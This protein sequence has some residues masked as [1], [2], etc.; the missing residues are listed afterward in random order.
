MGLTLEQ[1]K[2]KASALAKVIDNRAAEI[3]KA[4][5]YYQGEQ[6]LAFASEEYR[7]YFKER[8]DKF[9]DNW[10][11][12]V[13]DSPTER[14]EII[15]V[16]PGGDDPQADKDLM[17]VW[18][19]RGAD[20]ESGLAFLDAIIAKRSYG[21]VWGNDADETTPFVSFESATEAVVG[22]RPG[23][24]T[25]RVA[26]LKMWTEDDGTQ[27]ADLYTPDEVWALQRNKV[28]GGRTSSG[29]VIIS[30][31]VGEW[32]R[33]QTDEL[34]PK[35]NPLG[36]VPL[37]EFPNRPLLARQPLSDVAGVM[38]MQDA[39]NLLW[40]QLFVAADYASFPQRVILGAE[41]P[42]LPILD[43]NGQKVGDQPVDLRKFAVDRVVWLEN[44]NAK[45]AE[46][47]A[48]DLGV[49][50]GVIETGVGHMAAQTRTPQ[51]Y[52]IG[53]MANLSGDALVVAETGL[54]KRTEEKQLYMGQGGREVFALI[55]TAQGDQ[56]KAAAVRAG[57]VRWKDAAMRSEAQLVDAL[58]K[59]SALGMPFQWIAE[60]YGLSRTELDRVMAMRDEALTRAGMP[61]KPSPNDDN[62]E[63][64][65]ER[66]DDPVLVS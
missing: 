5:D 57:R 35:P 62:A 20:A 17:R 25:E 52:L 31:D 10:T 46:W 4:R 1:A 44:P 24:R 7:K 29:L 66:A 21:M 6:L 12:V 59:L 30:H 50:T 9:S 28:T 49:Y 38:A 61:G 64:V 47:K 14:M 26:G 55:A 39:I 18:Q 2:S 34:N 8:Y 65:D 63:D 3:E 19:T 56:K 42:V 22:Y 16:L 54:V 41:R 48:A 11:G 45:I 53:K 43:A 36:A 13:A 58:Q 51:H 40:S 60:R 23:S 37:V 15:D 33:R 32:T 27:Y